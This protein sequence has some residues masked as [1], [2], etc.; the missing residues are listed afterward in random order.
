MGL[1]SRNVIYGVAGENRILVCVPDCQVPEG[2]GFLLEEL[3]AVQELL[4]E[5]LG[6][7]VHPRAVRLGVYSALSE[8]WDGFIKTKTVKSSRQSVHHTTTTTTT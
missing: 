8:L 2:E 1:K 5:P 7:L 6:A 3:E 4:A